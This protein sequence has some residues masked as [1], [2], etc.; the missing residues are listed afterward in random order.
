MTRRAAIL[1]AMALALAG[2]RT[3]SGPGREGRAGGS[4]AVLPGLEV[5]V[6]DSMHLVRRHRV[7]LLT[8]A[9][10]VDRTGVSNV[11]YLLAHGVPLVAL[12]APEHGFRGA[13]A[14]GAF[15][16]NAIDSATGLPI[17]S[18]YGPAAPHSREALR[19]LDVLLVDLQDVGARYFTW[20]STVLDLLDTA[21]E[22]ETR[23]V[24]LDRPN[25]LAGTMQGNVLDP[26]FASS[27]GRIAMPMRHG[28]T[29]GELV[30]LAA[31]EL[32][33]GAALTVV[34]MA[35]WRRDMSFEA[36]GLPFVPPSPNLRSL[37][38][39]RHYPGLCLFEG[40]SLSVGRGTADPFTL[41]GAPGL[42]T[43]AIL[44]R[45]RAAAPPGVAFRGDTARPVSPGDGKYPGHLIQAI[46]WRVTDPAVYDPTV[47]ALVVLQAVAR[48]EGAITWDARHFDRLAG[49]DAIRQMVVEGGDLTAWEE[50]WDADRTRWAARRVGVLLYP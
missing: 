41:I 24:I 13:A 39:I 16:E 18:L 2:C 5:L 36:T 29:F 25:P 8:N 47:T 22:T 31:R 7:A 42:D 10:G 28:L 26:A 43:T 27:V 17:Y 35:G 46:R 37:E 6:R 38:A 45:L 19:G 33:T 15:V 12:F 11:E 49:T 44:A 40:T 14:P 50:R 23:V 48:V 30:R 32:G 34:P 20:L 4:T 9:A 3:G 21:A 1:G